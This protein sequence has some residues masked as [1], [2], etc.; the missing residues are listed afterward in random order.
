MSGHI[1]VDLGRQ[2]R[3]RAGDLCEYCRLPQSS[4]EA[5]FHI[6]HIQSQV[7]GGE[8][9]LAN[10]A[11]ACVTCSLRKG[12]RTHARDVQSGRTVR[13]FHPR[14]DTWSNHFRWT[15]DW[16]LVGLTASGRATITALGMNRPAVIA[17][18][19]TLALLGRFP[20]RQRK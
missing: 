6:D 9:T 5:A 15:Q 10:L 11:L 1:P 17:I 8:T 12:A 18:R 2:V 19:R 3:R 7:R 4:Q 16:K 14:R 20:V 13:L